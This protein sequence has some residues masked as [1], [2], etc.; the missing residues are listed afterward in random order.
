MLYRFKK[1]F[2][3]TKLMSRR[4]QIKALPVFTI[5]AYSVDTGFKKIHTFVIQRPPNT[6]KE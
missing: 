3:T 4:F 5:T 2:T 1:T 6:Q